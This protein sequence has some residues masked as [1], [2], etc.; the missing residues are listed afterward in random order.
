[1]FKLIIIVILLSTAVSCSL[2]DHYGKIIQSKSGLE[3]KCVEDIEH[4]V[5]NNIK[6]FE[7]ESFKINLKVRWFK[8]L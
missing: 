6:I 1:M 3:K 2:S 4:A 5:G 8:A 7:G